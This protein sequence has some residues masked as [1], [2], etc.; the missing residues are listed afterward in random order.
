MSIS[1]LNDD[2]YIISKLD[3]E[4]NDVGGMSSSSLKRSFDES[5]IKIQEYI[6]KILIPELE[7]LGV[8]NILR[9]LDFNAKYLRISDKRE[10]EISPDGE[11][12][13]PV[14]SSGHEIFDKHGNELPKRN[15]LKFTDSDVDDDGEYT[16]VRGVKGDKG[17]PG[18][19]GPTGS[20]GPQG[21]TGPVG[22]TGPRGLEG[23]QGPRGLQ[24]IQGPK[25]DIGPEGPAGAQGPEGPRG[26]KGDRGTDGNSFVIQDVYQT[27][28]ELK[29]AFPSGNEYAYQV[30]EENREIF[31]WSERMNDWVTAGGLQ[32]PIGPQGPA[33]PTGPMGPQGDPGP[34]GPHGEQGIQGVQGEQGTRGP[35]GPKG[36]QGEV[37]ATGPRGPEGPSG[38]SAYTYAVEG[39]YPGS[40]P[41][42][43][44]SLSDISNA[45]LKSEK[46][47]A[48]GVATLGTDGRIPERQIPESVTSIPIVRLG[49]D[50][51]RENQATISIQIDGSYLYQ[52]N[53]KQLQLL[54]APVLVE[55]S[56]TGSLAGPNMQL[57]VQDK[58]LN[59]LRIYEDPEEAQSFTM[60]LF[61][62]ALGIN[63]YCV[64][65]NVTIPIGLN[66]VAWSAG[67]RLTLSLSNDAIFK[68]GT[69]FELYGLKG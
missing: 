12:W 29:N 19:R 54:C 43:S 35:E 18:E 28:P 49:G 61:L 30:I 46:G 59:I 33:G 64:Y 65:R 34:Q 45:I 6:N 38:K 31:I 26:P 44:K 10:I 8:L 48:N 60:F 32:G 24:G 40:E 23:P 21:E 1:K 4:P 68:S 36:D 7:S 67:L 58:N 20:R 62:S 66:G 51:L 25:G 50:N 53:I 15:K 27:L 57:I 37:G 69:W 63:G 39:G 56:Y 17:D 2:M 16:I 52:K 47:E 3:D 5:G 14:S 55:G 9:S 42:F 22:P 11:N 41:E 13:F